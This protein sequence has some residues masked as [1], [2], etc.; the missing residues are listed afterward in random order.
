MDVLSNTAIQPF[1]LHLSAHCC[2]RHFPHND[3]IAGGGHSVK[4]IVT[5][6]FCHAGTP[7][8]VWSS[9]VC[10]ECDVCNTTVVYHHIDILSNGMPSLFRCYIEIGLLTR[11][12]I[13][14]LV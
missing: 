14:V 2:T 7:A 11:C 10:D 5:L 6:T 9:D 1:E 8:S 13:H 12:L 4:H 3:S